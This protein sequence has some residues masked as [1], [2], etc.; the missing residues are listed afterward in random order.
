MMQT[1]GNETVLPINTEM[2]AQEKKKSMSLEEVKEAEAKKAPEDQATLFFM[3]FLPRFNI[4]VNS[5]SNKQLRKVLMSV[6]EGPLSDT[7]YSRYEPKMID[8]ISMGLN[9]ITARTALEMHALAEEMDK[10][11][12]TNNPTMDNNKEEESKN[13][14]N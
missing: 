7:D 4:L 9:L 5:M 14:K 2:E 13:D 12:L 8:A 1:D 6:V 3:T 10:K 11:D